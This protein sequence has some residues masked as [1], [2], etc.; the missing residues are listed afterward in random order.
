M[1]NRKT[2]R[3]PFTA[4][5][6]LLVLFLLAVAVGVWFLSVRSERGEPR[7]IRYLLSAEI[8][9]VTVKSESLPGLLPI[10]TCVTNGKGTSVLGEVVEIR[11]NPL[12]MAT[13]REGEVVFLSHP[14]KYELRITVRAAASFLQGDGY[15]IADLRIAAGG[16]GAF[17]AGTLLLPDARILSV[18]EEGAE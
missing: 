5:L 2:N 18:R 3:R 17:R 1:E 9:E 16:R 11:I 4:D 13:V 15:R 7:E 14:Q 8:S 10:G 12:Q 6:L